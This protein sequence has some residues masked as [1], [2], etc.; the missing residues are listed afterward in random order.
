MRPPGTLL[1]INPGAAH[2]STPFDMKN[3][4]NLLPKTH[5]PYLS[6]LC[7]MVSFFVE[8]KEAVLFKLLSYTMVLCNFPQM[9]WEQKRNRIIDR[10]SV[11]SR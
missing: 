8:I 1:S 6:N 7:N 9:I 11:I 2:G 4:F 10:W 5:H 3:P